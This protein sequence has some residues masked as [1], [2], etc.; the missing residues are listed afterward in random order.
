MLTIRLQRT[1]RKGYATFRVVVQDSRFSP[2]SGRVVAQLGNYN[3][4]TKAFVIDKQKTEQYLANGAKPTPRVV[5]LLE[6]EKINLPAWV[7]KT[8]SDKK[9]NIRNPEKLREHQPKVEESEQEPV[10]E[11]EEAE[12]AELAEEIAEVIV[13]EAAIEVGEQIE[14][15]VETEAEKTVEESE[16]QPEKSEA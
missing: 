4:H 11:A 3:P 5:R 14:S 1:G 7:E 16:K 8:P 9:R 12:D 13:E 15:V 10:A 6:S 2:S